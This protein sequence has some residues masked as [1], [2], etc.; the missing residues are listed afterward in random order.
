VDPAAAALIGAGVGFGAAL[1][2]QLLS[3]SL[4]IKRDRRNQ[5][6]E[7][8]NKV[9]VVAAEHLYK[10]A[11]DERLTQEEFEAKELHPESI[12]A[13]DPGLHRDLEPIGAHM[14]EGI[15]LLQIHFGHDHP[16][17]KKYT[18]A[19]SECYEAEAKWLEHLRSSQDE[20]RIK[21]IPEIMEGLR[22][23]QVARDNW[24]SEARVEVEKL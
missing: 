18:E 14:G 1:A 20:E 11:R 6:R 2:S 13:Q 19:C 23:A 12:A 21:R 9:I 4:S 16:L 10:P 3:H 22:A 17:V 15:S 8:L 5:R 7:R 24:M